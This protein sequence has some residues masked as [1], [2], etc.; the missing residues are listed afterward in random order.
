MSEEG[1]VGYRPDLGAHLPDT[2][3]YCPPLRLI[4]Y[5]SRPITEA[6]E[7]PGVFSGR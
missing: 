2:E 1:G 4:E 6:I 7:V 5:I 3:S